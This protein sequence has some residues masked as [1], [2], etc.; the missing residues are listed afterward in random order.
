MDFYNI[1]LGFISIIL[2][3]LVIDYYQKQIK[4]KYQGLFFPRLRNAGIIFIMIGLA[5]IIRACK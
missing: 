4:I 5:L 3:I 2:G 1:I